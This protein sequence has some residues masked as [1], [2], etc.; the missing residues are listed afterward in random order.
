MGD[1]AAGAKRGK[2]SLPAREEGA[3][4]VMAMGLAIV[5]LMLL[6]GMMWLGQAVTM[7]AKAATAADL[8]A[9]A[10]ADAARGL[11]TGDPCQ[12]AA[13]MV[14]RHGAVLVSCEVVGKDADT[15]QIEVSLLTGLPWPAYSKSRAGP[16]PDNVAP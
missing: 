1:G 5:L 14:A 12:V 15:V 8:A 4:T 13:D 11:T 6:A 9:L 10:A 7:A 3:G 16:P 2:H